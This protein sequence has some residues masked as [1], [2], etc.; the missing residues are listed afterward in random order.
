VVRVERQVDGDWETFADMTG[1]VQTQVAFPMGVQG[2]ADTHTGR[3]EWL[4]T[5]G[6]EAYDGFPARL[7]STPTGTYRFLVNGVSRTTGADA[8][9]TLTSE[10]FAVTPWTGVEVTDGA[11]DER[12]DVSFRVPDSRYPRSYDSTFRTIRDDGNNGGS[13]AFCRTCSFRP[14]AATAQAASA[15][16]TVTRADGSTQ[17]VPAT[18]VGGRWTADTDL[19][20][21]DTAVVAAGAVHDAYGE[22]NGTSLTLR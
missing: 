1:E 22:T 8:P 7:G 17:Q 3:Q 5:A 4:W 9:Y 2:V 18:L 21:G 11:V 15:V 19:L 13:S 12:G 16:V 10:P 14:W 20:P 6:F